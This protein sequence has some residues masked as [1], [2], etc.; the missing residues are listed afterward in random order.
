MKKH[1]KDARYKDKDQ[2][3]GKNKVSKIEKSFS[4]T[5]SLVYI[6]NRTQE[7]TRC[8]IN[9]CLSISYLNSFDIFDWC[10]MKIFLLIDRHEMSIEMFNKSQ[11][12]SR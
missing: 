6:L 12:R 3:S 10:E 7:R 9:K 2:I 11:K 5:L 8:F 4:P 1:V